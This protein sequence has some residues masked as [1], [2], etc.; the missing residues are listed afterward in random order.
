MGTFLLPGV[1][2]L[3]GFGAGCIFPFSNI[4]GVWPAA[5]DRFNRLR[6]WEDERWLTPAVSEVV[7]ATLLDSSPASDG[8][9]AW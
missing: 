8:H 5:R 1:G 3:L 2:T 9:Q 4:Y 6:A 7:E